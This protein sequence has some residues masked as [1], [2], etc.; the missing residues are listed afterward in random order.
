[1]LIICNLNVERERMQK[2]G[3]GTWAKSM[4]GGGHVKWGAGQGGGGV[5]KNIRE[6]G[7]GGR[8]GKMKGGRAGNE[9]KKR[10]G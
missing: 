1:M 9:R 3:G 4:G 2:V 10:V 8:S 7:T 5:P 6:R